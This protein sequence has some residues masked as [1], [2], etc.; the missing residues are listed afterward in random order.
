MRV[1]VSAIILAAS[2]AG[3][4]YAE[5]APDGKVVSYPASIPVKSNSFI[6]EFHDQV[7]VHTH[8]LKVRSMPDIAVDHHYNG[9]FKGMA[10][11]AGDSVELSD[12]AGIDGVRKVYPNRIR[13]LTTR[14]GNGNGNATS[15]LLH[16]KTGLERVVKEVRLDGKGVKI[17]IIDSG[18]DYKHPDLGGCWKT[19]GCRWQY[20]QDFI[21]DKYDASNNF[22]IKPNPTPMDCD[23]HGTHVSG[24]MA[25]TG[26]Q[27]QGIAPGA[28]YGMYRVF[29][30][31]DSNGEITTEDAIIIKAME[32]AYKDGHDIINL[33]VGGGSWAE[34]PTSVV[35]SK[36]VANGVV[37]IAAAG[38]YGH[39]GLFTTQSPSLGN[40]VISVGSVDNW[41]Y[42]GVPL[43]VHTKKGPFTISKTDVTTKKSTF[44]FK[45]PVPVVAPKDVTGS[46]NCCNPIKAK[47]NGKL[48][49]I[50]RGDC[51]FN[52]KAIAAQNAGAVG[53]LY[54][55]DQP[56]VMPPKVNDSI[57]IPIAIV[58]KGSGKLILA[59]LSDGAVTAMVSESY[60]EIGNTN[61]GKMSV[62][63]SYG[64][65]PELGLAPLLSAPG[66]DIWSVYPRK[67]NSYASLS[68]TS[69][70]ASYVSG[71][72]ALVKQE[73]PNL[74]VEQMH[75][76]LSTAC[77]PIVD[78]N[79]RKWTNPYQS[80]AGL[81]NIY[82]AVKS[83]FHVNQT[84]IT[85]NDTK[86]EDF[87]D[88][89]FV[90]RT[91]KVSN[92]NSRKG[93][94]VKT[95]FFPANSVTMFNRNH[96][97]SDAVYK[98]LPLPTWPKSD[99]KVPEDTM[100]RLSCHNCQ[101]YIKPGKSAIMK[102]RIGRPVGLKE[103]E[104][105]FY[106]GFIRFNTVWDTE[107]EH[108]TYT[109]P[110]AGYNGDLNKINALSHSSK[111]LPA[112]VNQNGDL[113]KDPKKLK[114]SSKKKAFVSY[115][116]DTPSRIVSLSLINSK[117]KLVGYLP[118]G[119][120]TDS[121]RTL[122]SLTNSFKAV[123][124]GKVYPRI[125]WKEPI[126]VS[127]GKYHVHL[128]ALR[129]FGN[130][131]KESDYDTWDSDVFTIDIALLQDACAEFPVQLLTQSLTSAATTNKELLQ[132]ELRDKTTNGVSDGRDKAS[133][134]NPQLQ[135]LRGSPQLSARRNASLRNL[136]AMARGTSS[137]SRADSLDSHTGRHNIH[138][139]GVSEPQVKQTAD[140]LGISVTSSNSA[141]SDII[142]E[143]T[144]VTDTYG[145]LLSLSAS[146][147]EEVVGPIETTA[148]FLEW[149][150]KVE[151]RLAEGQD[152]EA[153]AFAEQLRKH[154][155]QCSDMLECI[156]GIQGMLQ[157]M[158]AD[159]EKVCKQTGGVKDA[160][161][162][163]QRK[164][165]NFINMANEIS[166]QLSVYNSLGPISQ[167]FNS[168]GDRVCLND[169]FLPSLE[170][171]EKA[172][173]FIKEHSEGRDS[174]LYLMRFSQCRMRALSLIKMHALR[175]FKTLSADVSNENTR[176]KPM[177]RSTTL[178]VRFRTSA[179]TLSP[180]IHALQSR[181]IVL[182][183]T[184]R[185]VFA[186]VQNAYFQMRRTWLRPYILDC[187][188]T[189]AS[190]H[191]ET[192]TTDI[193]K[194]TS[195]ARVESLR[196][197]CAFVMNVCAD[198][199][200]LYYDF[201]DRHQ[202]ISEGSN[203]AMSTELREYLDS[204]MV[205]FHEHVRPLIIHESDVAVLA[206][207]SMTLLTYYKP[208]SMTT[209]S[210][211][212]SDISNAS[213][214]DDGN[215][216]RHSHSFIQEED[217]L[218]AFYAVVYQILQDAQ[219]RL[220]YKAQSYI[221]SNISG[222]KISK[223]DAEPIIR[224]VQ[225]SV[226]LRITDP[227]ELATFVSE[228]AKVVDLQD[229][230]SVS[231]ESTH[232]TSRASSSFVDVV[233]GSSDAMVAQSLAEDSSKPSKEQSDFQPSPAVLRLLER[234]SGGQL[235]AEDIEA[236]Q[237]MYPPVKNYHWLVSLIDGCLDTEVQAGIV[238]E[239]LTACKQNLLNQGARFVR[240][241]VISSGG[242]KKNT[243]DPLTAEA[244]QQ[245]HLFIVFNAPQRDHVVA[246]YF[247]D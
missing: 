38:D 131:K 167:L 183:S 55:N 46:A 77:A 204:I 67:K 206:E 39:D 164:R 152:Q 134:T 243:K 188:K 73:H 212:V 87:S 34:D 161:A 81:I 29:S 154:V 233:T 123:I 20:G 99:K 118:D 48:A 151:S 158:E 58:G 209:A 126:K 242:S 225:L 92:R 226:R 114:I 97:L 174:E 220:A 217:G 211:A 27:V 137:R 247:L 4:T 227:E 176:E 214:S 129:L 160:C 71:A 181:S 95:L 107:E 175:V 170:R 163:Y 224:W 28:T 180:L 199:Y 192:K 178:Y 168:P 202:D 45:K 83:R 235:T 238:E 53:L 241:N 85:I 5:W 229:S 94:K 195:G 213:L 120:H 18:V 65:T 17:G 7:D 231:I 32:A 132:S 142:T 127:A 122:P 194:V 41:V 230:E 93:M 21:G 210:A 109:I 100:P 69:M 9:L 200:R 60:K 148:Q 26:T 113:I 219:Q 140:A 203:V 40:G 198:E 222:Y 8:G 159:Y 240:E 111:E 130:P 35:A 64:P 177:G 221:R 19:K 173:G 196:D 138:A 78:W 24:I 30:C 79:T 155:E 12:L 124:D 165:D 186:D 110:Y 215:A 236:L 70:A 49:F 135:L 193:T 108:F 228:A 182:G 13:K 103:D 98:Q 245:A 218:D 66:G 3:F 191:E 14:A 119:Y 36:L 171:T 232:S 185:Q 121:T 106:G 50:P 166:E 104:R 10:I 43:L 112:L 33:S 61:G 88:D 44:K 201:F 86:R 156:K 145:D 105:W 128:A 136:A 37:V 59:A 149:Y 72:A 143:H 244:E 141:R 144:A 25:A 133:F 147:S 162:D 42:T 208:T 172:I 157:N 153:H 84:I 184:E 187:L 179:V 91:L 11:T 237:W 239:A 16:K 234:V 80:G 6:L 82:N 125:T 117:G 223:Q 56:S 197:W 89:G 101:I 54:Y 102:I 207:I 76:R 62:F 216:S 90:I 51:T 22:V 189:I 115:K 52:E 74:S 146:D 15:T 63:S 47:L 190:E 116:L 31:A 246:D 2:S 68:G 57:T 169:E 23:G 150:G 205:I 1:L 139:S 75:E 96:T